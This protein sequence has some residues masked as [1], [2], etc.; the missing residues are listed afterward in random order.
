MAK[1]RGKKSGVL[2]FLVVCVIY[3][4]LQTSAILSFKRHSHFV[5]KDLSNFLEEIAMLL[6]L[7]PATLYVS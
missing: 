1:F 7:P 3:H 6:M 5:R 2:L 4:K